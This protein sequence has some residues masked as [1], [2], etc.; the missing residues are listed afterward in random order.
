MEGVEEEFEDL[1]PEEVSEE[2]PSDPDYDDQA[3]EDDDQV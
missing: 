1:A 2:V 3:T